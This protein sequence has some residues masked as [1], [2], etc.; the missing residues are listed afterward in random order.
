MTADPLASPLGPMQ[1]PKASDVLVAELREWIL[2]GDVPVGSSLPSERSLVEQTGLS[3]TT[4]HEAL[5]ILE[6]QGLV[7]LGVGRTGG[8]L[9]RRLD[10]DSLSDSL[11]M[12]IRGRR[13]KL[14]RLLEARIALE[15]TCAALAA[16]RC[17]AAQLEDLD[18]AE[19]SLA[20]APDL[21][22]FLAANIHWHVAV[23]SASGNEL[24][25][26]LLKALSR[27]IYVVATNQGFVDAQVR[28]VTELAHRRVGAAIRA[29]DGPAAER[30]MAR[31]VHAYAAASTAQLHP[32]APKNPGGTTRR[33]FE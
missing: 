7:Q 1:V 15:P 27:S 16:E 19:E 6:V 12:L 10:P 14:A 31:H 2:R 8:A 9:V 26:A 24:L 32:S 17:T 13:M 3:R 22:A 29:G 4:V 18:R 21:D 23:A 25:V 11:R 20:S 33:R 30:R 28:R 5:R